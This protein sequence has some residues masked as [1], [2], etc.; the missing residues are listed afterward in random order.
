MPRPTLAILLAL[1]AFQDASAQ[2]YYKDLMGVRQTED[3]QQIYKK[4][5]V[6]KVVIRSFDPDGTE[7]KDFLCEQSLSSDY[8]S[9][10]THTGS[11]ATGKSIL[12]SFFDNQ[13]RV[14]QSI[15]SSDNA[16]TTT[17]YTYDADGK[18]IDINSASHS[19]DSVQYNTRE[20]HIWQYTSDG[21]PSGML[22]IKDGRDTT[23]VGLV[24]DANGNVYSETA[25]RNGEALEHYYYYYDDAHRLTDIVRYNAGVN[26]M[27]PD[28]MFEYNEQGTLSQ[29]TVVQAINSSYLVWY[30]EYQP[31]GLR[32]KEFCYDNTKKLL[33]TIG[34]AYQQ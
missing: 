33:G 27:V 32:V 1:F 2:Y 31:T 18:I 19:S 13:G 25:L 34:Y 23:L 22:R 8:T 16:V 10:E 17:V 20:E 12:T 26:R 14:S 3:Q 7:N 9:Q 29:M 24:P 6:R 28:Y 4:N 21:Q 15:D 11:M 30:Y 5:H